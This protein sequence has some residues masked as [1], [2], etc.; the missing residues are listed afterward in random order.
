[1]TNLIYIHRNYVNLR[2]NSNLRHPNIG[3]HHTV[4]RPARA[5]AK[6]AAT[7]RSILIYIQIK[8]HKCGQNGLMMQI[9]GSTV[10]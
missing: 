3:Q 1:M 2:Q 7:G 5:S 10:L 9:E 4:R 6:T 8:L